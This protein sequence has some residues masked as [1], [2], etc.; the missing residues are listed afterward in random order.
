MERHLAGATEGMGLKQNVEEQERSV[1]P[2][3][4]HSYGLFL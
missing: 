2:G 4:L 3:A 1:P